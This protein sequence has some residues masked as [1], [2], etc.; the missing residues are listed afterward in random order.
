[1]PTERL[2]KENNLI[3]LLDEQWES[4]CKTGTNNVPISIF[5]CFCRMVNKKDADYTTPNELM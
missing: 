4:E 3:P 5:V 1:M 2:I